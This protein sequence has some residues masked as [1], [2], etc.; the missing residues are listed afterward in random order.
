MSEPQTNTIECPQCGGE[1]SLRSG[2]RLLACAFCGAALFV[3]RSGVVGHYW[4][5]RLLDSEQAQAALK[6]WM[7]GN[8]TVKDLD[9]KS[10]IE[11]IEPISFPV[12]M[13][14]S[15][16]E[17]G[18]TAYIEPAAPTPI[19]QLADLKVPAG[20]LRSLDEEAESVARVD[21]TI[22][23][24]TAREWLSERGVSDVFETSLV[25]LPLW[26]CHY[27]FDGASFQALVDG[28]TGEVMAAVFPEKAEAPYYLVAAAGLILFG[29][30]GLAIT[31]P[32][33]KLIA[34]AVTGLP[35][36]LIAYWVA[37]KV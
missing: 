19:P 1:S 8:D 6:R 32:L 33:I 4:L 23:L 36:A 5:P 28:S 34:Y 17:G 25:E 30:L 35:L 18:E 16:R 14:R 37:R 20:Q 12:W 11:S 21:A 22:P 2:E 26:R 31:H 29:I 15:R 10:A 9:R 13:F 3:D 24:E 27:S 7:A